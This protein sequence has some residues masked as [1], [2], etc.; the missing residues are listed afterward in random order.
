MLTFF[1]HHDELVCVRSKNF[2]YKSICILITSWERTVANPPSFKVTANNP[3]LTNICPPGRTK[4]LGS[5]LSITNTRK[6]ALISGIKQLIF[7]AK[8][9]T[10]DL[11]LIQVGWWGGSIKCLLILSSSSKDWF[12]ISS[13]RSAPILMKRTRPIKLVFDSKLSDYLL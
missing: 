6:L 3:V 8:L 13:S 4:A 10:T 11:I 2:N 12:D 9:L 1:P 5:G 7:L